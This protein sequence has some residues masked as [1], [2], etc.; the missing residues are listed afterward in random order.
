MILEF[1]GMWGLLTKVGEHRKKE[2][3]T[4]SLGF[5]KLMSDLWLQKPKTKQCFLGL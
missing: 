1:Y 2:E 4:H 3:E 5:L